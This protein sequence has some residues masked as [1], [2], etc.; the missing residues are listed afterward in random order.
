LAIDDPHSEATAAAVNRCYAS[1]DYAEG[2]RAYRERR[3][4]TFNGR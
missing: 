1:E 3:A 4:P 2:I